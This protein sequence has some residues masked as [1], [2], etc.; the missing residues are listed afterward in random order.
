[1]EG[2]A[3]FTMKRILNTSMLFPIQW[4]TQTIT[5]SLAYLN[6]STLFPDYDFLP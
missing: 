4:F 6:M 3:L 5:R 1:M 2:Q